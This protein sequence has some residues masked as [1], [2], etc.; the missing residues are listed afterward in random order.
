MGKGKVKRSSGAK[1]AKRRKGGKKGKKSKDV[2]LSKVT[3]SERRELQIQSEMDLQQQRI[4]RREQR[5]CANI[6]KYYNDSL[7]TRLTKEEALG[8]TAFTVQNGR[9]ALSL[10][11]YQAR[12]LSRRLGITT[13]AQL[14]TTYCKACAGGSEKQMVLSQA[15]K[16]SIFEPSCTELLK[17]LGMLTRREAL[18]KWRPPSVE[19]TTA[20]KNFLQFRK[21]VRLETRKKKYQ[22]NSKPALGFDMLHATAGGAPNMRSLSPILQSEITVDSSEELKKGEPLLPPEPTSARDSEDEEEAQFEEG[23]TLGSLESIMNPSDAVTVAVAKGAFNFSQWEQ[24][25]KYFE[26]PSIDGQYNLDSD[27]SDMDDDELFHSDAESVS[28]TIDTELINIA[29]FQRSMQENKLEKKERMQRQRRPHTSHLQDYVSQGSRYSVLRGLL[30]TGGS[31]PSKEFIFG[32]QSMKL[33]LPAA[34]IRLMARQNLG[35]SESP[36]RLESKRRKYDDHTSL[37][38]IGNSA[39]FR[40]GSCIDLSTL[41]MGDKYA[42]AIASSLRKN[43]ENALHETERK[44]ERNHDHRRSLNIAGNNLTATGIGHLLECGSWSAVDASCNSFSRFDRSGLELCHDALGTNCRETL[45][46][47]DISH[48]KIRCR[49]V[50]ILVD[51]LKQCSALSCLELGNNEIADIGMGLLAQYVSQKRLSLGTLDLSWQRHTRSGASQFLASMVKNST[52]HTLSIAGW[53][54]GATGVVSADILKPEV[55]RAALKQKQAVRNASLAHHP[56]CQILG[57]VFR[58]NA[59]LTHLDMSYGGINSSELYEQLERGLRR[60]HTL[61]GLHV[62]G[63]GLSIDPRGFLHEGASKMPHT[64]AVSKAGNRPHEVSGDKVHFGYDDCCWICDHWVEHTFVATRVER[65]LPGGGNID[66]SEEELPL[67]VCANFEHWMTFPLQ[68]HENASEG[69][70]QGV[71]LTRMVPSNA[72][73]RHHVRRATATEV[74][75]NILGSSCVEPDARAWRANKVHTKFIRPDASK[76]SA[77]VADSAKPRMLLPNG[78][79]VGQKRKRKKR[80]KGFVPPVPPDVADFKELEDDFKRTKV[81]R[82]IKDPVERYRVLL[83]L[84]EDSILIRE[85]FQFYAFQGEGD[86]FTMSQNEITQFARDFRILDRKTDPFGLSDL[87]SCFIAA[88]FVTKEQR[89]AEAASSS[90]EENPDRELVRFEFIEILLRIAVMKYKGMKKTPHKAVT[91]LMNLIRPRAHEIIEQADGIDDFREEMKEHKEGLNKMHQENDEMLLDLFTFCTRLNKDKAK[92]KKGIELESFIEILESCGLPD[93]DLTQLEIKQSFIDAQDDD[94]FGDQRFADFGE[95]L[96]ALVRISNE[97]WEEGEEGAQPIEVKYGW[98]LESL[99][100]LHRRM[101]Q[102]EGVSS[103]SNVGTVSKCIPHG[104]ARILFHGGHKT[105]REMIELEGSK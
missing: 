85:V 33:P 88:N 11:L 37:P 77:P 98:L 1:K 20:K 70:R 49:T 82:F 23:S 105:G 81:S 102:E 6:S 56:P 74:Y 101:L 58:K 26:R 36:T 16:A 51:G 41:N 32:C 72:C 38:F 62:K 10:D 57:E 13:I 28:D 60:N 55:L 59:T 21:R 46:H 52:I 9:Q 90:P 66:G 73:L 69:H 7:L 78:L 35:K 99:R 92:R 54:M 91:K 24:G 71:Q 50:R 94:G 64:L 93:E 61:M 44:H 25:L 39:A 42:M 103:L 80:K 2:T 89:A 75:E 53:P 84:K 65:K 8:V 86:A 96:E 47:L 95:F 67:L 104:C 34:L 100:G 97:K 3:E 19:G 29:S 40:D 83:E 30:K 79:L 12:A 14:Y 17:L 63:N 48:S 27:D 43:Q 15:V 87:D 4:D 31:G 18:K 45:V 22:S 5:Q 76:W 68:A